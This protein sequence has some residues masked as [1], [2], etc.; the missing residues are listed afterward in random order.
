MEDEG[1]SNM[2]VRYSFYSMFFS[3]KQTDKISEVVYV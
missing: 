1:I 2:T 3:M